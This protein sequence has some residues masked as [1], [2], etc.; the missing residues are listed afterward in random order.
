ME[1]Y[2]LLIMEK[3]KYKYKIVD[4]KRKRVSVR[5]AY[6]K[7]EQSLYSKFN[8]SLSSF[9]KNEGIDYHLYGD[10]YSKALSNLWGKAKEVN[11][12][13]EKL[14]FAVDNF[15]YLFE[16]I[17]RLSTFSDKLESIDLLSDGSW[18]EL[19]DNLGDIVF[20]NNDVV[21]FEI[22]KKYDKY[23][24]SF[25]DLKDANNRQLLMSQLN[26]A[27]TS[28]S[29]GSSE[30]EYL[31]SHGVPSSS[32]LRVSVDYKYNESND[33]VSVKISIPDLPT[34]LDYEY[35][36]QKVPD[37]TNVEKVDE[38]S[39]SG[40]KKT[41][42]SSNVGSEY[43]GKIQYEKEKQKTITMQLELIKKY[44][45]L[46]MSNEEIKRALGF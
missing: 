11:P 24:N 45:S 33:S 44:E 34:Y 28:R 20:S 8:K 26:S 14:S 9:F 38:V 25:S 19:T 18:W 30:R 13:K 35:F 41:S 7:R 43:E 4:G 21:E 29:L 3:K 12:S 23:V 37:V 15:E 2:F 31:V 36:G 17:G 46:G 27:I 5:K 39:V 42:K 6:I 1:S 32:D 10:T 40:N 22:D 16:G